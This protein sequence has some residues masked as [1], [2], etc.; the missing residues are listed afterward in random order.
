LI[1]SFECTFCTE[2][3][4]TKLVN[5]APT[6]AAHSRQGL[7]VPPVGLRNFQLR[8]N[9]YSSRKNALLS[10]PS[11]SGVSHGRVFRI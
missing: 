8:R 7:S 6:A 5:D 9:G 2:C 11:Q 3:S 1:C 4:T 10:Y